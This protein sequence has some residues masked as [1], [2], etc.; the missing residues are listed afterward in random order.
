MTF[1]F[2]VLS[3]LPFAGAET[4]DARINLNNLHINNGKLSD[5][6]LAILSR[7]PRLQHLS[8]Q[9]NAF[10]DE[11]LKRLRDMTHLRS[12]WLG[13]GRSRFTDAGLVHLAKLTNL[14]ELD[15]QGSPLTRSGREQ[16][17]KLPKR[18]QANLTPPNAN[19]VD[20]DAEAMDDGIPA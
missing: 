9:E 18:D 6:S 2:A 1:T 17:E 12:L 14:E 19:G 5:R 7:L 10:T 4:D 16:L 20:T 11:G 15:L 13:L 8:L 3:C